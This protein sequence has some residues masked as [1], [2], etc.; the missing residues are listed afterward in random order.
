MKERTH[1]N[2]F[3]GTKETVYYVTNHKIN[4]S[5]KLNNFMLSTPEACDSE[6]TLEGFESRIR[7]SFDFCKI[8]NTL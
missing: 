8:I 3:S 4:K 7:V 5:Q 1:Q 2:F 6:T